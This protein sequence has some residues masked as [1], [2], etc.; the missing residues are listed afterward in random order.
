MTERFNNF[1]GVC[2]TQVESPQVYQPHPHTTHTT[3]LPHI[4]AFVLF[5]CVTV[6][7]SLMWEQ[8]VELLLVPLFSPNMYFPAV[9]PFFI[10]IY[11]QGG[12]ESNEIIK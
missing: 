9:F 8:G 11:T 1:A 2:R 10:L 4:F 7:V 3:P 12:K 6:S 5:A